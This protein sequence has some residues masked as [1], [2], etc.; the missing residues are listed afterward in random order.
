MKMIQ[1]QEARRV[2]SRDI[3]STRGMIKDSPVI[4]RLLLDA[5]SVTD[6]TEVSD[7]SQGGL[8]P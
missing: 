7:S 4:R 6:L 8:L 1:G 5:A 2:S 3:E